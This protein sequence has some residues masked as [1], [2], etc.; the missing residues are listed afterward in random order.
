M[1]RPPRYSAKARLRNSRKAEKDRLGYIVI[2][3]SLGVVALLVV[4]SFTVFSQVRTD[5]KTGC[6]LDHKAPE[7][8]TILLVDETDQ[9]SRDE[10]TYAKALILNEY[11][12]LPIGGRLTVRNVVADPDLAEDIVVCRMDDGSQVLGIGRNPKMVRKNFE[13]VAGARLEELYTALRTAPIQKYS[14][15]L[16]YISAA[17]DRANFGANIENRRLVLL[18]DM[19]QHSELFSQYGR[20]A[21]LKPGSDVIDELR[22]DMDGVHVR[23]HY[24]P[25]RKLASIQGESH[26][27]FW[28]N[29]LQAMGADVALGHGLLIGEDANRETWS[30]ER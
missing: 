2:G 7:A 26:R 9:L 22:R 15:L 11:Y 21:R 23:I 29:H 13:K 6:L 14:P 4:L 8:H 28:I 10:L 30:D 18:S 5:K 17:M 16:E 25:R 20:G 19:A 1:R 27:R 12:W 24:I 3:L